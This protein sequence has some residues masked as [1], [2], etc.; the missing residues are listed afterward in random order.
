MNYYMPLQQNSATFMRMRDA[1]SESR[2]RALAERDNALL[3]VEVVRSQVH[4]SPDWHMLYWLL[5]GCSPQYDL[6]WKDD[7][8]IAHNKRK[9]HEGVDYPVVLD[10]RL[11]PV[12]WEIAAGR[13]GEEVL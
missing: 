13:R 11:I 1:A 5:N 6:S 7:K 4:P 9:E 12:L 8:H 3:E 2:D 10:K